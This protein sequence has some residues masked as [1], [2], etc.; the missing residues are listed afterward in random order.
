[1]HMISCHPVKYIKHRLLSFINEGS[2][3]KR[4]KL[5]KITELVNYIAGIRIPR[6]LFSLLNLYP[7]LAHLLS[8]QTPYKS[9]NSPWYL[10]TFDKR[11]GLLLKVTDRQ[12]GHCF[13]KREETN[14][15]IFQIPSNKKSL[16]KSL[17]K[18][19]KLRELWSI[20]FHFMS[21]TMLKTIPFHKY[22]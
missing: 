19:N 12:L 9:E 6:S 20:Y 5:Y 1:M 10:Q 2:C 16:S 22:A 8:T 3:T 21:E 17:S 18:V 7:L 4:I 14:S 13:P 11:E 15:F